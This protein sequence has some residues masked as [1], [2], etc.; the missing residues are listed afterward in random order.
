MDEQAKRTTPA[1][2]R[3]QEAVVAMIRTS[4]LEVGARVPSERELAE[5]FGMSRMTVRQGIEQLVRA[6]VLQQDVIDILSANTR[7]PQSNWGDLNG[8]LNALDLGERRLHLLLDEY[9]DDTI[10]AA[11]AALSARAEALMRANIQALPDGTYS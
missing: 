9:G 8:Q 11:L 7:V 2:V 6:G 1:Y 5:R 3:A 4:R 10:A